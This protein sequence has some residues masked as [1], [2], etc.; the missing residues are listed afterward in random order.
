[1]QR[2]GKESGE[3]GTTLQVVCVSLVLDAFDNLIKS[4]ELYKVNNSNRI[5]ELGTRPV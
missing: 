3:K 5:F 1:M 2:E 4:V